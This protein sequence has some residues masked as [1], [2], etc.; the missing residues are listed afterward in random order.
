MERKPNDLRITKT[1]L[2]DSSQSNIN[3]IRTNP[4]KNID[5][6][7]ELLANPDKKSMKSVE[8]SSQGRSVINLETSSVEQRPSSK[9]EL[10]LMGDIDN[11]R[12]QDD[13]RPTNYKVEPRRD[14][15]GGLMDRLGINRESRI[16]D[17]DVDRLIR[18]SDEQRENID[19]DDHDLMRMLGEKD[20][21]NPDEIGS[22]E[23]NGLT[24]EQLEDY[25]NKLDR[26][27]DNH[28]GDNN[29]KPNL[30][31]ESGSQIN[32]AP[33]EYR[34][35]ER[36]TPRFFDNNMIPSRRNPEE[37]RKEKEELLFKFEK[38]RRLGINTPKRFNM[39]SDIEEMKYE[40][41]RIKQQRELES[42]VNFQRKAMMAFVTGVEYLNNKFDPF[43]IRLDG[44]SEAV[45]E[46]QD[47]YTE[48]F[49][50][51]HEKYKERAKMAPELKLLLTLGGS[52]FMFHMSQSLFKSAG[53]GVEDLMK[54]NP[55]L[56]RQFAQAAI[57]NMTP[58]NQPMANFMAGFM[59]NGGGQPQRPPMMPNPTMTM[60]PAAMNSMGNNQMGNN[61]M[62]NN[63]MGMMG[64]LMGMM[65]MPQQN[66]N[67][68]PQI[69]RGVVPNGVM[70]M[71]QP[72]QQ[73]S[74]RIDPPLVPF[75]LG[76]TKP[77][78]I[79]AYS[80]PAKREEVKM[81]NTTSR[82]NTTTV[83]KPNKPERKIAPPSGVDDILNELKSNTED[84]SDIISRTSRK[85]GDE[86]MRR[87]PMK[88]KRVVNI[89]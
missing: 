2:N 4:S 29:E 27:S 65:G 23:I 13:R 87:R 75:D 76:E 17:D 1:T 10:D 88:P 30:V 69:P 12:S 85:S 16:S 36:D 22:Q 64:N 86:S 25:V 35:P 56:A 60:P 7:L 18:E 80:E 51:L 79:P 54:Q 84:L 26:H 19:D 43:D 78:P 41:N 89:Q 55:D 21:I 46:N 42:S 73:Q 14:L 59:P 3:R 11:A 34:E 68:N 24:D 62:G 6:G 53:P 31:S 44:W 28:S 61:S 52:A 71:S 48:I 77:T 83:V 50:E 37:E 8:T 20:I 5:I 49:E 38:W 32:F 82:P 58:Q 70:G 66:N 40:Y 74:K 63:P 57:N 67:P 39:S 15:S 9:D 33:R 72:N 81:I 45:Y 47:E